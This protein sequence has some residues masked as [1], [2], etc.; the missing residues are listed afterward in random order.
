MIENAG[1]K[2]IKCV[3]INKTK[4]FR[5]YIYSLLTLGAFGSDTAYLQFVIVAQK[6]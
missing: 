5:P 1:Y 4:S 2:I 6:Q 3:G